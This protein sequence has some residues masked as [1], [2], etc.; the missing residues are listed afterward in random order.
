MSIQNLCW[1]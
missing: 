1:R